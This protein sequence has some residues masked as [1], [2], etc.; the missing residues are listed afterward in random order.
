MHWLTQSQEGRHANLITK[1]NDGVLSLMQAG[2]DAISVIS[3]H[4]LHPFQTHYFPGTSRADVKG[5]GPAP[6]EER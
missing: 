1:M 2:S 3:H 4:L 5:A 6:V